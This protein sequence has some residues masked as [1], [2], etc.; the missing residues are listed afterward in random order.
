[1]I[2]VNNGLPEIA[3]NDDLIEF[4]DENR[5]YDGTIAL[6]TIDQI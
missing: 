5:T 2:K 1:M 6:G 4:T 3:E